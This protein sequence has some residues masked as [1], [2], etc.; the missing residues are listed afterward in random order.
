LRVA[1]RDEDVQPLTTALP[2]PSFDEVRP[3]LAAEA[4][5]TDRSAAVS[6]MPRVLVSR[7]TPHYLPTGIERDAG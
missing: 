4:M 6:A 2:A 7:F 1:V 5:P 3:R